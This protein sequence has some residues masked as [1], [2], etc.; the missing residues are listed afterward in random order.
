MVLKQGDNVLAAPESA[1]NSSAKKPFGTGQSAFQ[2]LVVLHCRMLQACNRIGQ[3][4]LKPD[5]SR[6]I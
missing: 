1:T 2:G 3:K 5:P 6:P 4:Q